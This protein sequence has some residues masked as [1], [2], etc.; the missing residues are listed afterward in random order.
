MTLKR[1]ERLIDDA[2]DSA[3]MADLDSITDKRIILYMNRVQSMIEDVLFKSNSMNNIFMDSLE[4]T[5]VP[6]TT[7]YALNFDTYGINSIKSVGIKRNSSVGYILDPLSFISE[8]E[9]GAKIGYSLREGYIVFNFQSQSGSTIVVHYNRKI[10]TL[11]KRFG[12]AIS[13]AAAGTITVGATTDDI[14]V[15]YDDFFTTVDKDGVILSRNNR[16]LTYTKETG[17]LTFTVGT[18]APIVTSYVIPGKYATTHSQ[19]PSE[20]EKVFLE[21]LERRLAQRKSEKDMNVISPLTDREISA[22]D[23]VFSK[24]NDDNEVPPTPEYS[25]FI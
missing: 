19:L 9:S 2:R 15:D 22:I 18:V 3:N 6:G 8:K 25:E 17:V 7:E 5:M 23:A 13:V 10:P 12:A 20:C 1:I 14:L 11:W 16:I 21:V 24:G 4:I